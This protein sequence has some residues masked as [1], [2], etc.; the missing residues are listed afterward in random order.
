MPFVPWLVGVSV[1]SVLIGV[2]LAPVMI[3]RLP[4]DY[5]LPKQ[6]VYLAEQ[7]RHPVLRALILTAKN[8]LG[9]LLLVAGF[10]M[11]FLPGQGLLTLLAGLMVLDYPGKFRFERW[12]VRRPHVLAALNWLRTRHGRAPLDAPPEGIR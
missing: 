3:L 7:S 5:F 11:L 12:L 8:A 2:L 4:A 9:G 6:R 1:V 10:A